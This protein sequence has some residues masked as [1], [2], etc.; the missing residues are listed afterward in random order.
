[1]SNIAR[2]S[3][4][5]A[6]MMET[7]RVVA[8]SSD[9]TADERAEREIEEK[10]EAIEERLDAATSSVFG[11]IISSVVGMVAS[12]GM[13]PLAHGLGLLGA[14]DAGSLISGSLWGKAADLVAAAQPYVG[15]TAALINAP[16]QLMSAHGQ[17]D[18]SLR[19]L[20]ASQETRARESAERRSERARTENQQAAGTL[21]QQMSE[22]NNARR[23]V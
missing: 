2:L 18:A 19:D 6:A 17:A 1:M 13:T 10:R 14:A 5:H 11:S 8:S 3:A 15:Q 20:A 21:L 16:G 9:R 23:K 12:I 7:N 22:Y 4:A